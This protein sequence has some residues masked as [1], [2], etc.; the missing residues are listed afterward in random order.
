ME[1]IIIYEY[2]QAKEGNYDVFYMMMDIDKFK[3]FNDTYGH[4]YG[5]KIL[6]QVAQEIKKNVREIDTVGRYGGDEFFVVL[7][8][9]NGKDVETT[10]KKIL[11]AISM[12][13]IEGIDTS[14]TVSIGVVKQSHGLPIDEILKETDDAM[15]QAKHARGNRIS[16]KI[17]LKFFKSSIKGD[18][19]V[20]RYF[21]MKQK[22]SF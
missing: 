9:F 8:R 3:S 16:F 12:I 14:L 6:Y 18:H 20:D 4:L 19:E 7:P 15:Y 17:F 22:S 5:D 1:S 13:H 10:A 2:K 21:D 11:D